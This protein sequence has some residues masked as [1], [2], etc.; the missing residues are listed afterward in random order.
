MKKLIALILL[1][2]L[3][4]CKNET[5]PEATTDIDEKPALPA[6]ITLVDEFKGDDSGFALPYAKYRL[7]N[8]LTE[9]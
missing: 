7:D 8:G 4:A 3:V 9:I 1:L 2:F 6:G 5:T